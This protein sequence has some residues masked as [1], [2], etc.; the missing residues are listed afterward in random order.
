MDY[1]KIFQLKDLSSFRS[2]L[3]GWSIL[4]IMM[5]HFRFI[6]IKP[7]GFLAQYGFAGVEVFMF[8]SGLGLYYSLEKNSRL[9]SFYIKRL[10]RIFPVYYLVGIVAS[11]LIFHDSLWIYLLRYTTIGYWI[12][13]P[14]FEWYIPAL[15]F[16]YLISPIVHQLLQSSYGRRILYFVVIL[17]LATSFVVGYCQ[18]L[19]RAHYF[20]LY[21]IPAFML[22]MLAGQL[23]KQGASSRSY[24][25]ILLAGIPIFAMCFPLHHAVYEM[26]YYSLLFLLPLFMLA[27]CQA[28]RMMGRHI[29]IVRQI[30]CASLEV[31]LLQTLFFSAINMGILTISDTW[32]DIVTVG[33]MVVCSIGG[34][35][36]HRLLP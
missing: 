4:W 25:I 11:L 26:K 14:Y 32:H 6:T 15:L 27:M 12:N 29:A 30:G 28:S 17:I 34:I 22:G 31:Y 21:R 18:S 2:E 19:N 8:V 10:R 23:I 16:L 9:S 5:L 36:L 3:M 7:L 24:L 33:L 35:V 1:N 20:L 13:L